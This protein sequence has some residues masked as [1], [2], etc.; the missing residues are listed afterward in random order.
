MVSLIF[1][2]GIVY[3]V[4]EKKHTFPYS[5]PKWTH[6]YKHSRSWS[7]ITQRIQLIRYLEDVFTHY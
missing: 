2:S 7:I 6:L 4:T 5:L 1:H 3:E